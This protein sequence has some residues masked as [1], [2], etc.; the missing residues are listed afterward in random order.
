MRSRIRITI[1]LLGK[2]GDYLEAR[3]RSNAHF[4]GLR[5][6]DSFLQHAITVCCAYQRVA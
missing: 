4:A 1:F 5:G 3:V 2:H 6:S